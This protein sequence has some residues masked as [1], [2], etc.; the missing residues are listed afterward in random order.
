MHLR[1]YSVSSETES[2]QTIYAVAATTLAAAFMDPALTNMSNDECGA[3]GAEHM[4][5]ETAKAASAIWSSDNSSLGSLVKCFVT[6]R[7]REPKSSAEGELHVLRLARIPRE[8]YFELVVSD[9]ARDFGAA[10]P[11]LQGAVDTII[12]D[13]EGEL[14]SRILQSSEVLKGKQSLSSQPLSCRSD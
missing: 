14:Q 6:L 2:R 7:P 13:D 3:L 9:E 12:T 4:A 1:S 11:Q 10:A 5:I 8:R